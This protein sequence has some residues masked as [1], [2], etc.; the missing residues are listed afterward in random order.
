MIEIVY[1]RDEQ[2]EDNIFA[3]VALPKNI[4]QIGNVQGNRRIYI[5]DYVMTYLSQLANPNSSYARG[6]ILVGEVK[7][8]ELGEVI[9]V[10]GALAAQNLEL[11]LQESSF[12]GDAWACI[13]QEMK[14]Y[15]PDLEVVGWFL[16]RMGFTTALNDVIVSLHVRNFPG[17]GKV[18]YIMDALENED[19]FYMMDGDYLCRQTGYYIY[20]ARNE[21][22]Q[23]YMIQ[24]KRLEQNEGDSQVEEKDEVVLKNYKKT[25]E[26]RSRNAKIERLNRK[27]STVCSGLTVAVLAL[28]VAVFSNYQMLEVLQ[29]KLV[30]NGIITYNEQIEKE[31]ATTQKV[32]SPKEK[33]MEDVEIEESSEI[34]ETANV[35]NAA[36]TFPQYYVVQNGDTLSSISFKMYNSVGYVANLMEANSF[37]EADDIHEG[38]TILIPTVDSDN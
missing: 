35:R 15:F 37:S 4:R 36:P 33:E 13:Y 2:T 3:G 25:M 8:T 26:E 32:V 5:E 11:D 18:L 31:K 22:M 30:E 21:A 14:N 19:A 20:Y 6:A 7:Q 10:S 28:G 12:D 23:N 24:S 9:F 27:L 38:D 16:S 1:N 29:S 17:E 34:V